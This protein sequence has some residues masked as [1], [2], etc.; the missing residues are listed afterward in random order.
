MATVSIYLQAPVQS[1]DHILYGAVASIGSGTQITT[2]V[3]GSGS[4]Q[5]GPFNGA[6][7]LVHLMEQW[8]RLSEDTQQHSGILSQG[9]MLLLLIQEQLLRFKELLTSGSPLI[10]LLLVDGK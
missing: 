1:A 5:S 9:L 2:N 8:V 10:I 6:V 4:G 7:D 3:T